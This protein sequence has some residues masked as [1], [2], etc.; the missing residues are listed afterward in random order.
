MINLYNKYKFHL[1]KI[2]KFQINKVI[3]QVFKF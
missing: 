1:I 2:I 3:N